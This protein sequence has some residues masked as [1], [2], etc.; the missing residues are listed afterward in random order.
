MLDGHAARALADSGRAAKGARQLPL[1]RR[2]LV[3]V[4]LADHEVIGNELVVVLRVGHGRLQKLENVP[5]RRSRRVG[6]DG[7]RVADRLPADVVDHQSRLAW[8]AAHVLRL[9][10][11]DHGAVLEPW[12]RRGAMD[13]L[14]GRLGRGGL[15]GTAAPAA[16]LGLGLPGLV[17]LFCCVGLVGIGVGVSLFSLSRCLLGLLGGLRLSGLRLGRLG[18]SDG[19]LSLLA[20][21]APRLGRLLG[22]LLLHLSALHVC[23]LL[24]GRLTPPSALRL[25]LWRLFR[26]LLLFVRHRILAL[27][28]PAWP[29]N[30]RVGA[31]SPSLWPTIDSETNTGTCLRPSWTAIV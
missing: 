1:E 10:A 13:R 16:R 30:R 15:G 22:G 26:R 12:R 27:S 6:K 2:T 9:G 28:P 21:S 3:D 20:A 11:H 8:R 7:T 19:L 23:T 17:G 24:S 31:N 14:R 5:G 4:D 29:R 25:L 18:L